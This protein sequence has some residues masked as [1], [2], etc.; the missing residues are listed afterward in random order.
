ML[1]I[2]D[3]IR[4]G[5]FGLLI[6]CSNGCLRATAKLAQRTAAIGLCNQAHGRYVAM[7]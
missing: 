5:L 1:P 6:G 7:S 4:G 3:R 2:S